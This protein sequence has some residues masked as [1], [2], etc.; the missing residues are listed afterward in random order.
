MPDEELE[1]FP[2][3]RNLEQALAR[4]PDAVIIA[5]PTALHLDVAS[6]AA[7]AGCHV[8][9]D[10]PVSGTLDR[11]EELRQAALSGKGR[12]LV[13]YQYRFHPGLQAVKS[14]LEADAVGRVLTA[15]AEDR[16]HPP[17][18]HP[19]DVFPHRYHAPP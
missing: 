15:T 7:R 8:L 12:I 6:P 10:K 19:W 9:V 11:T 5:N 1:G 17:A 3:E 14:W 13:G 4:S 18:R 16:A 2:T